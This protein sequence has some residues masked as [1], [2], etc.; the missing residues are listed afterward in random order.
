VIDTDIQSQPGYERKL[1]EATKLYAGKEDKAA[2][3]PFWK[4]WIDPSLA[5]EVATLQTN[6]ENYIQQ[7][8]LQ[9]VTGSKNIDSDWDA[10]VK[11]LEG[12]GLKRYL[13]IQQTA[14]DKVPK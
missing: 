4:V 10:Y 14:Y 3:Y 2:I 1:F 11:G 8:S 9:F 5:S 6:L 12:L 7:N 13:E